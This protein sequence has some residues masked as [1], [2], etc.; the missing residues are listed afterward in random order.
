MKTITFKLRE[1]VK[2]HWGN[3]LTAKDVKWKLVEEA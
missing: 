1:G 3:E 2:S